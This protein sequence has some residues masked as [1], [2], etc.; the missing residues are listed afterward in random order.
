MEY[1]EYLYGVAIQYVSPT[2]IWIIVSVFIFKFLKDQ[3]V[4]AVKL[5]ILVGIIL[6]LVFNSFEIRDR[7]MEMVTELTYGIF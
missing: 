7:I 6:A 3:I 2:V 4:N 5:C 1:L